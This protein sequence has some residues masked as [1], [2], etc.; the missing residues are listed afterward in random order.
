M[1]FA[2]FFISLFLPIWAF[3]PTS[4]SNVA[5]YWGQNSG[6]NQQ[7]LSYYCD[8]SAIDIVI[9][10]FMHVFPDPIQLN[11][12]NA[13]EGT[14]TSDNILKCEN[15]QEDIKYCQSKGKIILLSIGGAAG[16]YGFT[17]DIEARS[18]AHTV[19][20]LFGNSQTLDLSD[21]PFGDAVIDGFDFD[22]ENNSPTG[23]PAMADELRTIFATDTTRDY[24]LGAAPQCPYPDASVGLLLQQSYIDF[25]FIQ[26]YNNYCNLG[27]TSFN[28]NDWLNYAENVSP[29]KNVK[30]FVGV[31]G[32]VRAAGSGYNNP[33]V[34]ESSLSEDVLTS[35]YFGG[36]SLWDVSAG[37]DNVFESTNF[38]Q[39]VKQI[40]ENADAPVSIEAQ[41][42]A[43]SSSTTSTTTVTVTSTTSTSDSTTEATLL[44][45][46]ILDPTTLST[47]YISSVSSSEESSDSVEETDGITSSEEPSSFST[48]EADETTNTQEATSSELSSSSTDEETI[49]T[50]STEAS[51]QASSTETASEEASTSFT[52]SS[53]DTQ[54]PSETLIQSSSLPTTS[55]SSYPTAITTATPNIFTSYVYFPST[56]T[57]ITTHYELL[58][59]IT[60]FQ[61]IYGSPRTTSVVV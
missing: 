34:I 43:E 27:S 17:S 23:Y 10:S 44:T 49:E 38:V 24:Y 47:S 51:S 32:A 48:E 37:W 29:N 18:F 3:D 1:L 11:F 14:Y 39:S 42:K 12:A 28:W 56:F 45:S 21:R 13:C 9:V 58:T 31:P 60:Y 33:S 61:T 22:I 35:K 54:I 15:I 30:L 36:I 20:D 6:G 25:V 26:F 55:S 19:W 57:T 50:F 52:G 7:R 53:L 16:S 8:S 4:N 46:S 40:V 5:V 41:D 2:L 59:T